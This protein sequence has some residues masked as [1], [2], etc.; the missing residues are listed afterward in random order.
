MGRMRFPQE[1]QSGHL[2][3]GGQFQTSRVARMI[4]TEFQQHGFVLA[5]AFRV[6]EQVC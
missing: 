2:Q 1:H 4:L 6:R 5:T 3:V